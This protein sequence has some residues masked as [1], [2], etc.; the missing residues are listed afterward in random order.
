MINFNS[1]AKLIRLRSN[2]QKCAKCP[3]SIRIYSV[4]HH[5]QT[6]FVCLILT[7]MSI[8]LERSQCPL[9]PNPPCSARDQEKKKKPCVGS[10]NR[11]FIDF[12]CPYKKRKSLPRTLYGR[13]QGV[14]KNAFFSAW[15]FFSHSKSPPAARPPAWP[16]ATVAGLILILFTHGAQ[17]IG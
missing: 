9:P 5:P 3:P 8:N 17:H 11:L 14:I 10:I 2:S 1:L 7:G 13:D 6:H 12:L 4:V 16:T 15:D